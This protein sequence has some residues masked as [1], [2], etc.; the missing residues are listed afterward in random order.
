MQNLLQGYGICEEVQLGEATAAS[1]LRVVSKWP[2]SEHLCA[3]IL[4]S[5]GTRGC[6]LTTE[7]CAFHGPPSGSDGYRVGRRPKKTGDRYPSRIQMQKFSTKDQQTES[8]NVEN[9]LYPM[10]KW[11]LSQECKVGLTF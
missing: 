2:A 10:T 8:S 5:L 1:S 11:D 7:V 3:P 6:G 9:G 4:N